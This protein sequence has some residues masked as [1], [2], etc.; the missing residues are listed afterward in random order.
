MIKTIIFDFGGIFS[1]N[2][3]SWNT[4]Y[5][6]IPEK[7]GLTAGE[8]DEIFS[9]YWIEISVGKRDFTDILKMFVS[10][11]KNKVTMEDLLRIYSSDTKINKDALDI[12]KDLKNKGFRIIILSNESKTGE[13]IRLNRIKNFVDKIYSSAAIGLRKPDPQIF[14]YV[15]S[16]ENLKADEALFIDDR[17]RNIIVAEELGIRSILYKN[18]RQLKKDLRKYLNLQ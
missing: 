18:A 13:Q 10:K 5:K 6:R 1:E 11:S 8:L 9:K 7:T 17:E 3:D 2:L 16:K 4:M 15:L 14:K 12:L